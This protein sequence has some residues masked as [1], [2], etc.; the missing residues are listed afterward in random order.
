MGK[1]LPIARIIVLIIGALILLAV[2]GI[3]IVWTLADS[4]SDKE[5]RLLQI[6]VAFVGAL[7]GFLGGTVVK[8]LFD[9]WLDEKREIQE[10]RTFASELL[11]ELRYVNSELGNLRI[12]V[13]KAKTALEAGKDLE[14]FRLEHAIRIPDTPVFDASIGRLGLLGHFAATKTIEVFSNLRAV[15]RICE[16][17]ME[18][19]GGEPARV[20]HM[21]DRVLD[22][23]YRDV[24]KQI[25]ELD[26]LLSG[27][28]EP[29][30][31]AEQTKS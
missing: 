14:G 27:V 22:P 10:R 3:A 26:S 24:G 19:V 21:L 12:N 4:L 13:K 1:Q 5:V 2:I 29:D 11:S 16:A 25:G 17:M 23:E 30:P 6:I 9:L 15:E 18:R 7:V 28:A 20:A 31:R 8:F